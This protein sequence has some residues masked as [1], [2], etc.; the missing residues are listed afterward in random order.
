MSRPQS[1][2]LLGA[3]F[4]VSLLPWFV[5]ENGPGVLALSLLGIA[6]AGYAITR[7]P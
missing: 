6:M 5:L 2:V 1:M 4:L 7:A 3:G